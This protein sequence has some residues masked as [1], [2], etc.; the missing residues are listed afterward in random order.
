MLQTQTIANIPMLHRHGFEPQSVLSSRRF[1]LVLEVT[2]VDLGSRHSS[3]DGRAVDLTD[4]AL[5]AWCNG[6]TYDV[7]FD[8]YLRSHMSY[9][10]Y[11]NYVV[12]QDWYL[13]SAKTLDEFVQQ[14][15]STTS[16]T[17]RQKDSE[18]ATSKLLRHQYTPLGLWIG[19]FRG[20]NQGEKGSWSF[21]T[22]EKFFRMIGPNLEWTMPRTRWWTYDNDLWNTLLLQTSESEWQIS[23][24]L[25]NV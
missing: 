2:V 10:M 25:A 12:F 7:R 19:S 15:K 13:P 5:Q 18:F 4:F 6:R 22:T 21:K 24:R 23:Q 16:A 17:S 8:P 11:E 1:G 14:N 9:C 20:W 3:C